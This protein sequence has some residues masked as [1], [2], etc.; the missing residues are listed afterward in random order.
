M[1]S[2]S[3]NPAPKSKRSCSLKQPEVG[4]AIREFRQLTGLTQEQLASVLGVAYGTLN[5]WEN[6]HIQPSPLAL[7]QIKS[8]IEE[9]NRS[10]VEAIQKNSTELLMKYFSGESRPHHQGQGER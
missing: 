6:G 7:K 10:S 4:Q 9:L 1:W 5:R 3:R 2:T 8:V